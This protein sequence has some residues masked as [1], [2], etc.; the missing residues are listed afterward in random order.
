MRFSCASTRAEG[1]PR[2]LLLDRDERFRVLGERFREFDL[3][4]PTSVE[5][6]FDALFLDPPFANVELRDLAAAV[7][8]LCG[9]RDVPLFV[10]YNV[11]RAAEVEAALPVRNTG[12]V[13][14]YACGVMPN[15]ICLFTNWRP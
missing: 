4:K 11:K 7:E 5:Y 12:D 8:V 3:R 6:D 13:L 14:G 10:G 9:G 15:T 1:R 2:Y